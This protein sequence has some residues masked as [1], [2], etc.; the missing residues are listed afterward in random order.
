[1]TLMTWPDGTPMLFGSGTPA[2]WEPPLSPLP[3]VITEAEAARFL[4]QAT[5]GATP[6]DIASVISL[7][8][9]GW[10]D[11]QFA[12]PRARTY[13]Q[14]NTDLETTNP[15]FANSEINR[16]SSIW[17]TAAATKPDQLRQRMAWALAQIFVV[18]AQRFTN[19]ARNL[20]IM[21]HW[22][23]ILRNGAFGTY[24][25]L[26]GDITFSF[27]MSVYL[28]YRRNT[29]TA[30]N[31]PDQNY[32]REVMQLFSM[33]LWKLQDNGDFV[34]DEN[35]DKIPTYSENDIVAL[36]YVFTGITEQFVGDRAGTALDEDG[37]LL[38]HPTGV[39]QDYYD[40]PMSVWS[41]LSSRRAHNFLGVSIPA[42]TGFPTNAQIEAN[43][44]AN[45]NI[46]LDRVHNDTSTPAFICKQLIQR[47]TSSNPSPAYIK[48]VVNVFKN[49]G[50]GIRGDFKA[51]LKAILL[52][53]EVRR[54]NRFT[55]GKLREPVIC[56]THLIR[57]LKSKDA[58]GNVWGDG[59]GCRVYH[60]T[61]AENAE[62]KIYQAP[63]VFNYFKPTYIPPGGAVASKDLVAPE[64]QIADTSAVVDWSRFVQQALTRGGT[65]CGSGNLVPNTF[66]YSFFMAEAG[67]SATLA[68]KVLTYLCPGSDTTDLRAALITSLNS[69]PSVTDTDKINRI[70]A[71]IMMTMIV[72]EYRVQR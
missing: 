59:A 61:I 43:G 23:T 17:L 37:N 53:E 8:Y 2:R 55:S 45:I 47:F 63:S 42:L 14:I 66:D 33:G 3:E 25:E 36:S 32:A 39:E 16:L 12:L 7:G 48:R 64:M 60:D 15:V 70:K 4:N 71:A 72:P 40:R 46:A 20:A 41:N 52:D 21:I 58:F 38:P 44:R 35:G 50:S 67:T 56:Q 19:I 51:V 31:V 57:I 9:E 1:M 11:A 65:G 62:Q 69:M 10:I 29:E 5:F 6:D 13:N 26:L 22:M 54:P 68:D 24:R 49:N 30:T 34:L 18:A 28:D 27:P